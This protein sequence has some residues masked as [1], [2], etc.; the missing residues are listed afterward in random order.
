MLRNPE[1]PY[2]LFLRLGPG[3]RR[4]GGSKQPPPTAKPTGK[5]G[6]LRPQPFPLGFEVGGGRLLDNKNR[7]F[8]V[9]S[10]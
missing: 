6:V 1:A 7:R 4:F 5:G 3:N 2:L 9:P 8:L 10:F